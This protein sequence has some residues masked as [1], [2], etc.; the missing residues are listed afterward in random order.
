LIPGREARRG[1]RQAKALIVK[2]HSTKLPA[3]LRGIKL[4]PNP[5]LDGDDLSDGNC[6]ASSKDKKKRKSGVDLNSI[7]ALQAKRAK[8]VG[9]DRITVNPSRKLGFFN[10][11]AA[12]VRTKSGSGRA[13]VFRFSV[14]LP[15]PTML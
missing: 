14:A 10:K 6:N 11:G 9:Q 7:H 5:A 13:C 8:N 15:F 12:S 3:G 4:K 1:R 2:D